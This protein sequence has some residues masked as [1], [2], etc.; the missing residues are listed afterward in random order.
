MKKMLS[1]PDKKCEKS[2]F[3]I[4]SRT[5]QVKRDDRAYSFV[6]MVASYKKQ[7]I[8]LTLICLESDTTLTP[9]PPNVCR[10]VKLHFIVIQGAVHSLPPI[11]VTDLIN[12]EEM[13]LKDSLQIHI[14][15]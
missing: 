15:S 4:F 9:I 7:E 8:P 12:G 14:Q 13:I 2:R 3:Q 10:L 5:L 6:E 11:I 1:K